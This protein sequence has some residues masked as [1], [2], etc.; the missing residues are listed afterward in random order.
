[1][2]TDRDFDRITSG[3]LAEGPTELNDRVLEAALDEVH[4]T[5]QRRR[6][7]APWRT[8]AMSLRNV[9]AALI[10]LVAIAGIVAFTHRGGVGSTPTPIP[11]AQSTIRPTPTAAPTP[12]VAPSPTPPSTVGW[13]RFTSP[14][15]G[16]QIS[17][18]PTW[19][20]DNA[21]TRNWVLAT[22]RLASPASAMNGSA[23]HFNGDG[24]GSS[25]NTAVTGFAADV[26]AGM[27]EDAWLVSYYA[28]AA[29]CATTMPNFV[30]ITVDGHPG[31]LDPCYDAQ[32]IVFIGNRVYVFAI[33]RTDN[34]PLF[35]S[36]L[37][38]VKFP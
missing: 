10:V 16:Y 26:P 11:T 3:W 13:I 28:G 30:A 36:F 35:A 2:S 31:R 24:L 20:E 1:M 8:T 12:P 17:Y 25:G 19:Q 32:A 37:S 21:A 14:Q 5:K 18:P 15:Y 38:T 4:L 29:F 6:W 7:S 23:D 34:Q 27:S 22:D 9:A 33:H